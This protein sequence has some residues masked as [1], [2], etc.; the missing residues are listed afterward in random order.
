MAPLTLAVSSEPSAA[1]S[2]IGTLRE[3]H[4]SLRTVLHILECLLREIAERHT[5]PDFVLLCTALYYIDDFPERVHHRK[6]DEYLFTTLRRRTTKFDAVLDRLQGDH[7]RS[8]HMMTLVQRELV[9]YQGGAPDGLQRLRTAVDAYA[10]MLEEHMQAEEDLLRDARSQL[11][12]C[13]WRAIAAA[14]ESNNDPLMASST[15]DEFRRLR[16]RIVNL[17]PRKMRVDAQGDVT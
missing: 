12:E 11:T 16:A 9:H 7:V 3:E 17:L 15:R 13:D 4:R 8:A 1:Q 5:E 10:G 6:E 14:F 2:V